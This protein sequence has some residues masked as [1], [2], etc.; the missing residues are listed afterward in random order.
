[1]D[2]IFSS[3]SSERSIQDYV[4]GLTFAGSMYDDNAIGSGSSDTLAGLSGNDNLNGA[5]GDDL[6][7]GG[8]GMDTLS[9]GT[10]TNLVEGGLD[11]DTYVIAAGVK[12]DQITDI[13]GVDRIDLSSVSIDDVTFARI[14]DD[15][16]ISA[17]G[18]A[19]EGIGVTG[20]WLDGSR[21]EQFIFAEGTYAASYIESLAGFPGGV[22]YDDLGQPMFCNPYGLPV[23]FDLDGDGIELIDLSHSR[24][25]FDVDGDGVKERIGWVGRDDGILA[26]D[27]NGN[28]RI[29]D[30]SE[31]S[32]RQDF[33]GAGSDLE[34]LMAY[35]SDG[36][37]FLTADDDRF[38]EFLVWRDRNGNGRSEKN[39]LFTLDEL[40][41]VS[42][43][44]ER[45]NRNALDPEA[46]ANQLLATSAFRTADG[47][48]HLLG[49][50]ALFAD[51]GGCGCN[52]MRAQPASYLTD[53]WLL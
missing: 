38:S 22:C 26:L 3:S 18:L 32:F 41:I 31:I 1:M 34:G 23:V 39:E 36:D 4:E 15:L 20:Q 29:D 45:S 8:A 52:V 46:D 16:F 33:R 51:I 21:I 35:D 49:D 13:G 28:G 40:G 48:D 42:I 27:R 25:R 10:G 24:A 17:P 7:M 47:R 14:G 9:G 43:D 2:Q 11:A 19:L 30:F 53:W 12:Y 5:G 44:L 37:G 6:V 50:V